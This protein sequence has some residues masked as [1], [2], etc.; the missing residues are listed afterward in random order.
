[1]A[2]G[3]TGRADLEGFGLVPNDIRVIQAKEFLRATVQGTFDLN[4]SKAALAEI[5]RATDPFPGFDIMVDVRDAP[6]NLSLP[7]IHEVLQVFAEL[8][9]GDGHKGAVLTDPKR[10][11]SARFFAISARR[12]GFAVHAFVSFEEAFEWLAL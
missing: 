12:M 4:A 10:F 1:V 8:R 6:N 2:A 3:G 9:I 5:A 11:E 7:E